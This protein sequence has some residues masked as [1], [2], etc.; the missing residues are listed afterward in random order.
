MSVLDTLVGSLF[1][2]VLLLL[3]VGL[4]AYA[5]D[6]VRN[7]RAILSTP[8]SDA[9]FVSTGRVEL[10]GAVDARDTVETPFTGTD[11]VAYEWQVEEH[12]RDPGDA[13]RDWD[14]LAQGG[15]TVPF[16]VGDGTGEALVD[17]VERGDGVDAEPPRDASTESEGWLS[18]GLPTDLDL[19][20]TDEIVVEAGEDPPE[21]VA[22]FLAGRENRDRVHDEKRRFTERRLEDGTEVYVL[23]HAVDT[24]RGVAVENH[25]GERFVVSANSETRTALRNVGGGVL[26]FVVGVLLVVVSG[27][28]LLATAG[29]V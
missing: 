8:T 6:R 15:V 17:P 9:G 22:A 19:P 29:V 25:R 26:A 10:E 13:L 23:G 21:R 12:D 27:W 5:V 3:G 1:W 2:V 4:V 11:C 18:S 24:G 14:T 20:A 16:A 28:I 7:V